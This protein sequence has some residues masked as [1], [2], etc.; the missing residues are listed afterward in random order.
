[1][2]IT[3]EAMDAGATDNRRHDFG[4]MLNPGEIVT[5][6]NVTQKAGSSTILGPSFPIVPSVNSIDFQIRA[7]TVNEIDIFDVTMATSLN[8]NLT[9]TLILPVLAREPVIAI[10]ALP[11]SF[12]L[13]Y[14]QFAS[15]DLVLLESYYAEAQLFLDAGDASTVQDNARREILLNLLTA[16]IAYLKQPVNGGAPSG[17]VGRVQRATEG[18]VSVEYAEYLK[19]T[20]ALEAWLNLSPYGAQFWAATAQY[21][22][23]MYIGAPVYDPDPWDNYWNVFGP[24]PWP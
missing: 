7:G 17:I 22:T 21:R 16:H 13:N 3:W 19:S 6:Y 11:A 9:E 2:S 1:M 8:N 20:N 5:S 15:I 10:P 14:P 18:A 12:M 23:F 24:R 4:A